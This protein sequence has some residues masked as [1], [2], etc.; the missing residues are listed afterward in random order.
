MRKLWKL[1]IQETVTA[2]T[3]MRVRGS[4]NRTPKLMSTPIRRICGK[5]LCETQRESCIALNY[6]SF[7]W[8]QHR[9]ANVR[10]TELSYVALGV[11]VFSLIQRRNWISTENISNYI[12]LSTVLTVHFNT[13][14]TCLS[15]FN[16]NC[17]SEIHFSY[18]WQ[19]I[20]FFC[21]SYD[22]NIVNLRNIP[23]KQI[24]Y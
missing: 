13:K 16:E 2:D 19:E 22:N 15:K 12:M 5:K 8:S 6:F 17:I 23:W 1:S 7:D 24:L 10:E 18:T 4:E 11:R 14:I 21:K 9:V 3:S 20:I